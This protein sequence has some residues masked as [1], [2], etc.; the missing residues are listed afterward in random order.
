MIKLYCEGMLR[1]KT[2]EMEHLFEILSNKQKTAEAMLPEEEF[3]KWNVR[4]HDF[5]REKLE[6]PNRIFTFGTNNKAETV[7][8][9]FPKNPDG[10][11]YKALLDE[12]TNQPY[13]LIEE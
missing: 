7:I 8:I 6:L 4:Y 5:V 2:E 3:D 11:C 12:E 10:K 9:L 13:I 1:A